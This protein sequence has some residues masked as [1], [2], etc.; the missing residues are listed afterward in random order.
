MRRRHWLYRQ[1]WTDGRLQWSH[2]EGRYQRCRTAPRGVGRCFADQCR[3]ATSSVCQSNRFVAFQERTSD[4]KREKANVAWDGTRLAS[5]CLRVHAC[6]RE[7]LPGSTKW[8]LR[9]C[10]CVR[11]TRAHA[12][13]RRPPLCDLVSLD[14]SPLM[15]VAQCL[16]FLVRGRAHSSGVIAGSGAR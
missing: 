15:K 16:S 10:S 1:G 2:V 3:C 5:C 8:F 12:K 7:A 9:R 13:S 6:S 4:P 14:I 11:R